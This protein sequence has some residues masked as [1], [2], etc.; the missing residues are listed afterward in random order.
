MNKPS[1]ADIEAF[2][3]VASTRS[4]GLAGREL[5]VSQSTISRRVANLEASLGHRLV[6]RTTRKVD[7]T[8]AGTRYSADLQDVMVRLQE[9][10]TRLSNR[11]SDV[12]GLV[13][14]TMPTA[15]GRAYVLPRVAQLA[16]DHLKLRFEL[17]LSDRYVDLT[18]NEFDIAVRM[19]A[20]DQTGLRHEQIQTF[21]LTLCASP[22]YVATHDSPADILDIQNHAWL[23]QRV[24]ATAKTHQV[25]W[26]NQ[27]MTL[28]IKPRLSVSDS[29]S[30]KALCLMGLGLA[31]L[32]NYLIEN[33]L[34]KGELVQVMD[35]LQFEQLPVY[36][37]YAGHKKE[38]P[39]IAVVLHA[40][41]QH[42][43]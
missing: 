33:E 9:A 38:W 34:S 28:D 36:A 20:P 24:Y 41:R 13:R 8:G 15:F 25:V 35:D 23:A 5:G 2:L 11:S 30:L 39:S 18:D 7:L 16:A 31:V 1:L 27:K 22:D 29:T 32:P 6:I 10:A 40:L 12:E 3:K 43:L 37:V 17:D 21:G 26:K 42:S 19:T 14:I 4:F